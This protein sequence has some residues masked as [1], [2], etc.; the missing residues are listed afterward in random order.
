MVKQPKDSEVIMYGDQA[1]PMPS[2]AEIITI[3]KNGKPK[4]SK[5]GF[6]STPRAR[7]KKPAPTPVETKLV[8]DRPAPKPDPVSQ[9]VAKPA[10]RPKPAV[11]SIKNAASAKAQSKALAETTV[12]SMVDKMKAKAHANGGMLSVQDLDLMQADFAQ[13]AQ[14][15]QADIE[16]TLEDFADARERMKWS[17]ERDE[18]F[19]RLLVKQFSGLL[20]EKPS[21]KGINRR[22][23]PGYFMAVDM[24]LGPDKVESYHERCRAIISRIKADVGDDEFD[25]EHFYQERDAITVSLD[26]QVALAAQFGDYDKRANWF[27]NLV[28]SNLGFAPSGASEGERRWTLAE[29]GFRRMMDAMFA[30]LRKVM[31]SDTGRERLIKRHGRETANNAITAL[32]RILVG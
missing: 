14:S 4:V 5:G 16:A 2:R 29:Q 21:R 27:I 19:Y 15:I 17:L 32:K 18:P 6:E 26:A 9:A 10:P 25:W 30:D 11:P 3:G 31:S 1:Q 23:L 20:K 24:L 13:Q 28:N 12:T 7:E 8:A 22:M